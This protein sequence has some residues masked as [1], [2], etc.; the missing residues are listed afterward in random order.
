V[1]SGIEIVSRGRTLRG[2]IDIVPH[3]ASALTIRKV[4]LTADGARLDAT[5]E[6]T[7]IAGPVGHMDLKAGAVDL[8]QL[9]AFASDFMDGSGSPTTAAGTG[10]SGSAG[11]G[12]GGSSSGGAG[13]APSS[14]PVKRSAPDLTVTLAA[15][16]ATM[17][18]VSLEGLTGRAHLKGET[19][20]IDPM[21]FN[22]FGGS[23]NGALGA[24]M[25]DVPT[26]SWKAALKDVD[27]AA[28]TAF[29]GSPGVVTG[30]MA[31][32]VNLTGAGIDAATA[33]KTA[34]G[35]ARVTVT[36]GVV[37]NL[38]LVK[39]AVAATS[40]NPQAV[41]ASSQGPRDEPFSEL[42]ATL[43][44]AGGTASTQDLHFVSKDI[45]LDAGG[46]LR[47]DGSAVNL[48]GAVQMSEELSKQANGTVVRFT[49][50]DGRITLPAVVRGVAGKYSI[51]IDAASMARRA[52]TNEA[53]TQAQEAAKKGLGRLFRR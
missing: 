29:A 41:I 28:V 3:G 42:G 12:R 15:D 46:A 2:D 43:A 21:T 45:R 35:T 53:R 10:G 19:L 49:Q 26:F 47:L 1:L 14:A 39:S 8:D 25:G 32:D 24:T 6:I 37:Q 31:A 9:L 13:A 17:A 11:N 18:G 52:I 40:M 38:A 22:L 23:Y 33:M 5:G 50:Q 7:D 51:Q 30:R 4:A 36:N 27:V 48:Q 34:R 16:R 44:I 20:S